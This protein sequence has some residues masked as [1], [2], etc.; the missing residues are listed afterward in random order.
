[1]V[2]SILICFIMGIYVDTSG[3]NRSRIWYNKSRDDTD[4]FVRSNHNY[5]THPNEP[6]Y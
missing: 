3:Y 5:Y 6:R 1:M 2:Q 4:L